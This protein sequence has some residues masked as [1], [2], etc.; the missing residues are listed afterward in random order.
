MN[1]RLIGVLVGLVIL[2]GGVAFFLVKQQAD[3]AQESKRAALVK[4]QQ[5]KPPVFIDL[6]PRQA[7]QSALA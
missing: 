2:L 7:G 5:E 1:R 6:T 3:E 4:I